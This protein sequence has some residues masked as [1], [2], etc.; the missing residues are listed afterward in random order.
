M[1]APLGLPRTLLGGRER[2]GRRGGE[3]GPR[4]R[5][6][7]RLALALL[8]LARGWL[9]TLRLASP[10]RW[11]VGATLYQLF[12]RRTPEWRAF[13]EGRHIILENVRGGREG[14]GAA[15]GEWSRDAPVWR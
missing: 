5:G 14:G 6:G 7:G 8:S 9:K 13:E 3:C 2:A 11:S 10:R 4:P 12:A 1:R 15:S